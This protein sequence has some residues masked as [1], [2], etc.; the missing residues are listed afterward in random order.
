M[1]SKAP[2]QS[3]LWRA[4]SYLSLYRVATSYIKYV[5]TTEYGD[6]TLG[7]PIGYIDRR[8]VPICNLRPSWSLSWIR[9]LCAKC[10]KGKRNELLLDQGT[11]QNR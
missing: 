5:G 10:L 4:L 3:G 9:A 6:S 8:I 1:A 7:K 2:N 11:G